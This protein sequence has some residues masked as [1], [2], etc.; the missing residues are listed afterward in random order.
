MTELVV[1]AEAAWDGTSLRPMAVGV[2]RGVV[3][4]AGPPAQ[5]P[6]VTQRLTVEGVLLPGLVDHHVHTGLIDATKL[7]GLTT[8]VD[9][10]WIPS[11]I[12]PRARACPDSS[13]TGP[14]I[15][16]AGPILTARGGYPTGRGWAPEGIAWE[17]DGPQ[18]AEDAVHA[19]KKHEPVTV[20]IALNS[21]AG[22]VIDDETL[23]VVTKTAHELGVD[24]TAHTE[25]ADQVR[26]AVSAG[27]DRLAHTPWTEE[28]TEDLLT[29][30]ARSVTVV[31]TVDIHGWGHQTAE[32]ATAITNLRR[33]RA[34]GGRIR[35]GTDLGNGPLPLGVNGRELRGLAEAGL[36]PGEIL[37]AITADR[38]VPGA[39]ADLVEVPADPLADPAQLVHARPVLRAGQPAGRP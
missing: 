20:K 27:V 32:R 24:V 26:R 15:L 21:D 12:F 5:A 2:D 7:T 22:P 16:A 10:G 11:E 17:L 8:V 38:L 4:W 30:M 14:R 25:G 34:L 37:A 29:V 28:I 39:R 18:D 13:Y 1:I 23:A 6:A 33:F 36:T 35:Y 9:L 3:T 31:S 19:L